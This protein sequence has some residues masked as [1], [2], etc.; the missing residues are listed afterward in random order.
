MGDIFYAQ[1]LST[2]VIKIWDGIKG[3]NRKDCPD[4]SRTW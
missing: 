4:N 3:E 1:K 2:T